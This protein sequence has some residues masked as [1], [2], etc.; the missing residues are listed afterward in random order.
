M[1]LPLAGAVDSFVMLSLRASKI[2]KKDLLSRTRLAGDTL[3][4]LELETQHC[5]IADL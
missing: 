5:S 1:M 4:I 2:E 3:I